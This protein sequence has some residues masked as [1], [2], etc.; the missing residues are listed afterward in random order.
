MLF[1]GGSELR[2]RKVGPQSGFRSGGF[3][4]I[5]AEFFLTDIFTSFDENTFYP[6]CRFLSGLCRALVLSGQLHGPKKMLS[7]IRDVR[8]ICK[9]IF[10]KL[11]N[12]FIKLF[13]QC[14]ELEE[15]VE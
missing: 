11:S 4:A 7:N 13:L 3:F 15:V 10:I 1:A 9:R 8:R 12:F 5:K 2:L 6:Y 14:M